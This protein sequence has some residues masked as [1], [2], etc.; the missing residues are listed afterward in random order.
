M[1]VFRRVLISMSE[2]GI[3]FWA[4]SLSNKGSDHAGHNDEIID[5]KSSRE[6]LAEK[7]SDLTLNKESRKIEKENIEV[8]YDESH[9]VLK[10]IS[11]QKDS[12]GR[13]APVICYGEMKSINDQGNHIELLEDFL[14][15]SKRG[16]AHGEKELLNKTIN[17]SFK[18][19]ENEAKKEAEL[20]NKVTAGAIGVAAGTVAIAA[21]AS[22]ILATSVAA[23]TTTISY[24]GSSKKR[25]V[26]HDK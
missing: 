4:Q 26:E 16:F 10:V 17:E 12:L 6:E 1:K 18:E 3:Y 2:H 21:G 8:F 15:K 25:E 20:K 22:V 19:I 14:T 23:I 24:F 13:D 11:S 9:F 7:I 5:D